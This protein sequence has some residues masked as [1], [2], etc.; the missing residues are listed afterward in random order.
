MERR[1]EYVEVHRQ[2][3]LYRI[4]HWGIVSTGLVIGFTGLRLGRIWG[5]SIPHDYN[6]A[7]KIHV[8]LGFV[9]AFFWFLMFLQL[10]THEWKWFGFHRFPYSIRFLISET[11]AWLGIGPHIE[12]PRCY[13]PRIGDYREKIIPTEVVVPWTYILLTIIMGITGLSLYYRNIFAPVIQ[14][15][16]RYAYIL[17][18]S[19]GVELLR[20]I[21]RLVMFIYLMMMLVHAYA[22]FV[23]GVIKSM[24]TGKRLERIC[25]E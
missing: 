1:G 18:L 9:F 15:A 24:I 25:K 6:L 13:D 2:H 16:D 20:V 4:T 8:Y 5:V 19:S 11:L 7:L 17:G 22:C 21:H 10:V 12:D 14:F 3:L 23:F